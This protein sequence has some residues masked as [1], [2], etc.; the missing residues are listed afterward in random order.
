MSIQLPLPKYYAGMTRADM[1]A[2]LKANYLTK[3]GWLESAEVKLSVRKGKPIPWLTY[4]AIRFLEKE[5]VPDLFLFEY[6]GGQSTLF[7]AE[8]VKEVV[9]VD[10]DPAFQK[11]ICNN[12]YSNIDFFI[13]KE[14]APLSTEQKKWVC[15]Q[16]QIVDPDRTAQT[17]RSGQLNNTFQSY[18]FKLLDFPEDTF[19]IVIIDGM[20]RVLSTWAAIR[21]FRK[22][23][24]IVFDNTDRDFYRLAYALLNHAGYRRLDFWGMGPVNPYEWCTSVFYQPE[25]FKGTRWFPIPEVSQKQTEIVSNGGLGILVIGYNRPYHLQS[26]LESLRIQGRIGIVHVWIDGTQNRRE[27]MG[28]NNK[29]VK[30]AERYA[31]K[32]IRAIKGHLGIEKIMLDALDIMSKQYDRVIVLEDDCFPVEGGIDLFE[33]G[34]NDIVDRPEVYSVY[35]HHFGTEPDQSL[36]FTRFQG[37]GWAAH[38][39]QIRAYLPK[40]IKLFLM[41]ESKYREHISAKL[42]DEVCTR[43][44]RTPGRN[45]LNV[46]K[47]FFSWDSAT[48]F[49][50]AMDG[51]LHRR[52]VVP[53]VINTGIVKDIGHFCE[54]NTK[55]RNPPLNMITLEEAWA[56]YD[57]TTPACDYSK[58]SYGLDNLDN[59]IIEVIPKRAG[60]F[61]ELGANDGITQSNSV[62]LEAVGWRGLLIEANP[63]SYAKCVKAR[64]SALVEHAACVANGYSS[65]YTT[66]TDVGLMSMTTES[67]LT[68]NEREQWL[69]RGEDFLNRERQQIEVPAATLSAI[70]DKY[71]IKRVD[72]LILDVEGAEIEV[73]KG[74]DF[75]RHAPEMIVAE[76]AYDNDL[77][78]FLS[79]YGYSREQI[80]LER[81]YTRDCFYHK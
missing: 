29:T 80:L 11:H 73:L 2:S 30:V 55:F 14:N 32:E 9:T 18:A 78:T 45:V 13:I 19:D 47:S 31:V 21:H 17:Y 54:N 60:F 12:S 48:S 40:L 4:S 74:L 71:E 79:I 61:V 43:L 56:N 49:L 38:S 27:Y 51:V 52:T 15:K 46:L 1:E 59:I 39:T 76:D 5:I 28:A 42:T 35:G 23:G 70:L 3:S 26:V 72:L 6:G 50:T 41:N 8:R 37:W 62:L 25:R 24:F 36:D 64:P 57:K 67:N 34:L 53:A 68:G 77:A 63:A 65:P 33:K 22:G 75:D 81:K 7:W 66:I 69:T 10:H 58:S 44:D 16:P 20:A